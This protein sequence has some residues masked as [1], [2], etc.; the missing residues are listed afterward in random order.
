M[1]ITWEHEDG[2]LVVFRVSGKLSKIELDTA[3][4]EAES[5]IQKGNA[6]LLTI[7]EHF[8]GWDKDGNW[9][10]LSFTERNDPHIKKMA[11]VGEDEWRDL[12]Y[13]FTLKGLRGFP[14]EYFSADQ[15]AE[16]RQWLDE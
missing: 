10:D 7:A 13:T 11:I 14:I 4:S 3:Q 12:A 2:G 9:N 8:S 15:E 6:K 5:I 1:P 16:A